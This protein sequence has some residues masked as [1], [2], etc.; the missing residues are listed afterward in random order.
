MAVTPCVSI[1]TQLARFSFPIPP[2]KHHKF[3]YLKKKKNISFYVTFGIV[4]L[5]RLIP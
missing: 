2:C 5:V 3:F 4:V 1:G